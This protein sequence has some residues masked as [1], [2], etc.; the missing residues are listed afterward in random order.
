MGMKAKELASY[1]NV[2]ISTIYKAFNGASDIK[3]ETRAAILSTAAELGYSVKQRSGLFRRICVF[4]GHMEQLHVTYFLY[5][6]MIHFKKIAEE[7]G[8]EII[9]RSLEIGDTTS[10]N[11][12]AT[13]DNFEGFLI[14][15]HYDSSGFAQQLSQLEFPTVLVDD[16][17]E[18]PLVSSVCSDNLAGMGLIMDHLAKLG[19]QKIGLIS[20]EAE[21]HASRE[22]FAAYLSGLAIHKVQYREEFVEYGDYSEESG[23]VCAKKLLAKGVTALACASDSMAIGA[24]RTLQKEGVN[25][26]RDVSI[27]GYDDIR[28]CSYL[29]P[30]LT[31]VRIKIQDV[32]QQAFQCLYNLVQRGNAAHVVIVPSLVVRESTAPPKQ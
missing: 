2:S 23:G 17:L 27:T 3:P 21:S 30:G 1:M 9:I 16:K 26:P 18:N 20:G 15:G 28:L 12:I 19:H 5:E 7:N 31:T 4:M 14:L 13:Q 24:L 29:T 10:F 32:G 25:V 11:D 6:V 22:R 8:Y